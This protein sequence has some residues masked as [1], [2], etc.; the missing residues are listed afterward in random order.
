MDVTVL[1]V[2]V[3][4]IR[5]A[6]IPLKIP[7]VAVPVHL[8][9]LPAQ[10]TVRILLIIQEDV[11]AHLVVL[12]ALH[13]VRVLLIIQEDAPALH[14]QVNVRESVLPL[15]LKPV[16]VTVLED[17]AMDVPATVE[18]GVRILVLEVVDVSVAFLV[19]AHAVGNALLDVLR[20]A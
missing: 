15:A 16:Q 7:E 5:I 1:H 9:A 2:V 10:H 13:T 8:V 12:L 20:N 14:V 11:P 3:H 17:A 18:V 4:V 6:I 19:V